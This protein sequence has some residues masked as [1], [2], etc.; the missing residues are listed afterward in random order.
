MKKTLLALVLVIA[1]AT[2]Y[3]KTSLTEREAG[4]MLSDNINVLKEGERIDYP[5]ADNTI[6]ECYAKK[7][8]GSIDDFIEYNDYFIVKDGTLYSTTMQKIYKPEKDKKLKKV[9]RVKLVDSNKVLRLYDPL[10]EGSL[11]QHIRVVKIN[12]ENGTYFMKAV[13]DNW[14]WY[15]N[16][17][18]TGYCRAIKPE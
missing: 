18:S 14:T 1:C 3:A 15:R 17:I 4:I 16:T 6:I 13:Q 2:C 12:L 8:D 5:L 9:D 11:R 10:W 7:I